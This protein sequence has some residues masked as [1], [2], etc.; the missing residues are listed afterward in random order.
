MSN[1]MKRK[2][3]IYFMLVCF[4]AKKARER[5]NKKKY[6]SQLDNANA[7]MQTRNMK[8]GW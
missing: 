8:A 6:A 5:T 3:I 7:G 4:Y 2:F 1:R